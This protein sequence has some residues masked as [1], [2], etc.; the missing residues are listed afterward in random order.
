MK[1]YIWIIVI[2]IVIA[3]LLYW[4]QNSTPTEKVKIGAVLALTGNYADIGQRIKEG[5]DL[6]LIESDITSSFDVKYEDSKGDPKTAIE[7]YRKLVDI[8]DIRIIIVAH[9]NVALAL[10]PIA[11]K[12][13]VVMFSIYAVA[14]G[15]PESGEYVFRNDINLKAETKKLAEFIIS[16]GFKNLALFSINTEGSIGSTDEFV[17]NYTEL[18][19]E[20]VFNEKYKKDETDYRTYLAKIKVHNPDAILSLSAP[21]QMGIIVNQAR[22]LKMEMPFFSDW[23]PEGNDLI[24]IGGLNAEGITYTHT[25][26]QNSTDKI[27]KVFVDNYNKAYSKTAEYRS[28]V[29]YDT[30]MILT[31][32]VNNCGQ[33]IDIECVKNNLFKI[34]NYPGVTGLTSINSV[35]DTDKEI[36][37]KT[38]KNGQFVKLEE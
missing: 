28:A 37:I 10:A 17:K 19:G 15:I 30:F 6:A 38:I 14:P 26:D 31:K 8:D 2:I 12:D 36:I 32:A 29:A 18:G 35:G 25:F 24:T 16:K 20:I 4:S 27:V 9:S 5:I 33:N 1:K 3:G 22:D 11:E 21:K 34:K 23:H 7:A 13:K